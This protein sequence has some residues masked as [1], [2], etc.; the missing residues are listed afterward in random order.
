MDDAK[1]NKSRKS[2]SYSILTNQE[3]EALNRAAADG[4][5][6]RNFHN[7]EY[8]VARVHPAPGQR[9][10]LNRTLTAPFMM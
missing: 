2:D 4:K 10:K 8:P 1:I 7:N 3:M 9:L 6:G 5:H